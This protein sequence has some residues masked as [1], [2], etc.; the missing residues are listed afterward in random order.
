MSRMSF[1][2]QT[3][4]TGRRP[5][6]ELDNQVYSLKCI[7]RCVLPDAFLRLI[8][9]KKPMIQINWITRKRAPLFQEEK[10]KSFCKG[11]KKPV[12]TVSFPS[13]R[14][15]SRCAFRSTCE[16]DSDVYVFLFVT[17]RRGFR[18]GREFS[19]RFYTQLRGYILAIKR[20]RDRWWRNPVRLPCREGIS[21][22]RSG[23]PNAYNGIYMEMT[24][25]L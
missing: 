20:P 23:R 25:R 18:R 6:R 4:Q 2:S 17:S 24:R 3:H 10:N 19:S 1:E 21:S 22:S 12:P 15:I 5:R 7:F 16:R 13:L 9:Q 14:Q 8:T 11:L